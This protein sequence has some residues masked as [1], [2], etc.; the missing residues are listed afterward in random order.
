[1]SYVWIG[2]GSAIGGMS[3]YWCSGVVARLLGETLPWGTI[4]INILGS[5]IIGF[6]ATIMPAD[7]KILVVYDTRDFIMIGILGGY[8]TFSA[9]SLQTLNLAREGHW[10][11]VVLNVFLS[12][13]LC[14]IAVWVGHITA[15]AITR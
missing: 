10:L 8:T 11:L 15:T 9:F 13:S 14:L 4:L 7:N 2:I 1:M 3:R 5:L 6:I 12:V